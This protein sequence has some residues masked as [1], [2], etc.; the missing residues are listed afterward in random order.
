METYYDDTARR[1]DQIRRECSN[2]EKDYNEAAWEHITN[3][4]RGD[5]HA[6]IED[7]NHRAEKLM[8]TKLSFP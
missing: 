1:W 4:H 3:R 8:L 2:Q 5:K 7:I 6:L